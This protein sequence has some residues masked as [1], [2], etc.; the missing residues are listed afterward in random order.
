MSTRQRHPMIITVKT[1]AKKGRLLHGPDLQA[2][3]RGGGYNSTAPL[4][5][6]AS[7]YFS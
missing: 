1:G 6:T 5:I 3:R 7:A 2:H 4:V